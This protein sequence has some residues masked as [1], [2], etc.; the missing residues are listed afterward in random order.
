MFSDIDQTNSPSPLLPMLNS[1]SRL[2]LLKFNC[3]S[4]KVKIV[5]MVHTSATQVIECFLHS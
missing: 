2:S 1:P 5:D 3:E 4:D